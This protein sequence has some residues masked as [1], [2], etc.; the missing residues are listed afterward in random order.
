M[1]F[2]PPQK[3]SVWKVVFVV[4]ISA[5]RKVS[6]QVMPTGGSSVEGV[7]STTASTRLTPSTGSGRAAGT[8]RASSNS[9]AGGG[10]GAKFRRGRREDRAGQRWPGAEPGAGAAV[11]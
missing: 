9:G 1:L 3:A 10:K 2:T 5:Q 11:E 4:L 7:L 8:S 6:G